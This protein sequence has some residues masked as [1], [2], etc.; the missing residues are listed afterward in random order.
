MGWNFLVPK[1]IE[2]EVKMPYNDPKA[3]NMSMMTRSR[4]HGVLV[5]VSEFHP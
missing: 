5:R 2:K 3:G 4:I 1:P